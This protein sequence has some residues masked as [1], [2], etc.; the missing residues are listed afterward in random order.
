MNGYVTLESLLEDV[1][2]HL[3]YSEDNPPKLYTPITVDRVTFVFGECAGVALINF[4]MIDLVEDDGS[5]FADD[6]A[7][8]SIRWL[9]DKI[10]VLSVLD[11]WIEKNLKV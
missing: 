7:G 2:N 8:M 9:K 4:M 10:K 3:P 5:W 1:L 6:N 11:E